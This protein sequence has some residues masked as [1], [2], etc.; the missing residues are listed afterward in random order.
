MKRSTFELVLSA[1]K[2]VRL[3]QGS[4]AKLPLSQIG[5]FRHL[6]AV[7]NICCIPIVMAFP[8]KDFS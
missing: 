8:S 7:F 4:Q 5:S 6:V 1:L 3:V 2:Q